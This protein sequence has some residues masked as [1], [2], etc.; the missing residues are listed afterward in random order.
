MVPRPVDEWL[1]CAG[2]SPAAGEKSLWIRLRWFRPHF[3]FYRVPDRVVDNFG[4]CRV[5][6]TIYK[7]G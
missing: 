2:L 6:S 5:P 4:N 1:A 3:F 7:L